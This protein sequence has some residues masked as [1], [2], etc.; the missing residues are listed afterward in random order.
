MA[1]KLTLRERARYALGDFDVNE[2]ALRA[3]M[4]E[5]YEAEAKERGEDETSISLVKAVIVR[6]GNLDA[7]GRTDESPQKYEWGGESFHCDLPEIVKPDESRAK[8]STAADKPKAKPKTAITPEKKRHFEELIAAEKERAAKAKESK[9]EEKRKQG[10]PK[11]HADG[12][13]ISV[14]FDSRM[15]AA[16]SQR[17]LVW[18]CSFSDAVNRLLML[19]I[20]GHM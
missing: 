7:L 20:K 11:K 6:D 8:G 12:G 16:V 10:R 17:A 5:I 9:P 1:R 3:K 13:Q 2:N 15:K 14:W 18:H 4:A 19:A